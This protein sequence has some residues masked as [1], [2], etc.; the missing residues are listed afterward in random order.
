MQG[1]CGAQGRFL[2]AYHIWMCI[3]IWS[4]SGWLMSAAPWIESSDMQTHKSAA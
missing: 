1:Y 3:R 2:K 4:Q